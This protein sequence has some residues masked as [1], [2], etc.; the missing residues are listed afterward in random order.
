MEKDLHKVV[1]SRYECTSWNAA[2]HVKYLGSASAAKYGIGMLE[3]DVKA[4]PK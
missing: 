3:D 1:A 4:G 2:E